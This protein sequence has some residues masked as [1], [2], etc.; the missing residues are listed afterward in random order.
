MQYMRAG[1]FPKEEPMSKLIQKYPKF[2]A[3]EEKRIFCPESIKDI[4]VSNLVEYLKKKARR[5][6]TIDGV[7]A[8]FDDG[9]ILIRKSGTE[10][11]ISV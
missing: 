10:P 3:S 11:K 4:V 7:R 1:L 8:E 5:A 6:I 9:W 2:P